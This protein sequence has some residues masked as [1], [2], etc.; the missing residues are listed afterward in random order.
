MILIAIQ[1]SSV[2]PVAELSTRG[3]FNE[4]RWCLFVP[5]KAPDW[6]SLLCND[7]ILWIISFIRIHYYIFNWAA[8]VNVHIWIRVSCCSVF[9]TLYVFGVTAA[10]TPRVPPAL[11]PCFQPGAVS[12]PKIHL[13]FCEGRFPAHSCFSGLLFCSSLMPQ[14]PN[15]AGLFWYLSQQKLLKV[16]GAA[17]CGFFFFYREQC[18]IYGQLSQGWAQIL[19]KPLGLFLFLLGFNHKC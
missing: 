11:G 16:P 9:S 3:V 19:H 2:S 14:N 4:G 13:P 15:R 1:T 6:D 12:D 8:P 18:C 5:H 17:Q 10:E 7:Y